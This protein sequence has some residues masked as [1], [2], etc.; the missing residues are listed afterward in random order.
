MDYSLLSLNEK[1]S[2]G[3]NVKINSITPL[4]DNGTINTLLRLGYVF[5]NLNSSSYKR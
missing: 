1:L 3:L 5:T 2:D 4:L